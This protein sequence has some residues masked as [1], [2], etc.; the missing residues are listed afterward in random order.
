M[1]DKINTIMGVVTIITAAE[2]GEVKLN[3]LKK[4]SMLSATPKKAA[5]IIRGKSCRLIFSLEPKREISQNKI[6]A[7]KTRIK[8]N[9]YGFT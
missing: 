8:I 1:A 2:M 4:V 7:P 9:P 3:P 5:A 6:V